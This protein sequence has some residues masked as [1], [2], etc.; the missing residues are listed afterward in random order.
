VSVYNPLPAEV[1][2]FKQRCVSVRAIESP[3]TVLMQYPLGVL[4]KTS[5]CPWACRTYGL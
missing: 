2:H 1:K 3:L 5:H 4:C